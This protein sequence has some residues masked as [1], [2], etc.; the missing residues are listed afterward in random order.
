MKIWHV[1]NWDTGQW[2][3]KGV[4]IACRHLSSIF[5]AHMWQIMTVKCKI[6]CTTAFHTALRKWPEKM[7][8]DSSFKEKIHFTVLSRKMQ[9]DAMQ[10]F[11]ERLTISASIREHFTSC[12]QLLIQL[13]MVV[14]LV[15][16]TTYH[17]PAMLDPV[18]QQGTTKCC[19]FCEIAS[20]LTQ[21]GV[22]RGQSFGLGTSI[23]WLDWWCVLL[24]AF[25]RS[26]LFM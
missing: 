20:V 12:F 26:K 17:I 7:I 25:D 3:R 8:I 1:W 21:W 15:Q 24:Q 9:W 13:V 19:E 4:S 2:W 10:M 16:Q 11:F 14:R 23:A 18:S 5:E 22:S 6:T